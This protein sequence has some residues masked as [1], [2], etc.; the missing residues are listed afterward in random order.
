MVVW[1]RV[2]SCRRMKKQKLD[3]C[4]LIRLQALVL[5]KGELITLSGI[6]SDETDRN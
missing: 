6:V 3:F 5:D 2:L 1:W 4:A